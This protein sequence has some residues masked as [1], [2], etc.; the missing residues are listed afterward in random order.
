MNST[1]E[2]PPDEELAG[3]WL[4]RRLHEE[5]DCGKDGTHWPECTAL[6]TVISGWWE[7]DY[8]RPAGWDQWEYV[9]EN[10]MDGLAEYYDLFAYE[11]MEGL[12]EARLRPDGLADSGGS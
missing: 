10:N 3:Y 9:R 5:T 1:R 4:F 12:V 6:V 8:E 11:W 2:K 7:Q